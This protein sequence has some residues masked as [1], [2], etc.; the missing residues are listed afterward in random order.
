MSGELKIFVLGGRGFVGSAFLRAAFK[1]G[2]KAEAIDLDNYAEFKGK[3]CDLLINADGNS[4]KYLAAEKP[5]EEFE[6]SV[7]SVL[8]ALQ[9]FRFQGCLHVSSID[10][11]PDHE[12][13]ANNREDAPIEIARLSPYGFHKYLGELLVRRYAP[14]WMIIRLG[15]VLGPG[16]KKNPVFD[17]M[18]DRPLRVS[19]D[20]RYQYLPADLAAEFALDL[21]GKGLWGEVF[22][23][24]GTGAV[25]IREVRERLKKPLRYASPNVPRETYEINND[26]L[27]LHFDVPRTVDTVN[28]FVHDAYF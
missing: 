20:S 26:K 10:V 19:E 5:V 12:N 17:L 15:G 13:S 9:D 23:L 3:A 14:R 22:N 16:L 28:K 2:I 1:R 4:K 11:Y 21:V 27:R 6:L 8:K 18:N 7:A 24:C 25:A